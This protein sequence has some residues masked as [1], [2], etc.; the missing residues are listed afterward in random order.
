MLRGDAELALATAGS[1]E[2][3]AAALGVPR[4]ISVARVLS[5]RARRALGLPV[6]LG[7][8]AADLDL[9]RGSVAIE[10]WWWTGDAAADLSVSAWLDDPAGQ[11]GRLARRAGEHADTLRRAVGT[12]LD[13]WRALTLTGR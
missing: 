13:R 7:A 11:A 6:D 3:R 5:H 8:V 12:R 4:Y 10:A 2:T 9:V 1:L